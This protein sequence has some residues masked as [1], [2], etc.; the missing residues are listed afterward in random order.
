M[1]DL[2]P[3]TYRGRLAAV[4]GARRFYLADEFERRSP[5]DPERGMVLFM[6][7]YA[8]D[9]AAGVAPG[10]YCDEDARR[11]ARNCLLAPGLGELLERSDL[12]VAYISTT[13]PRSIRPNDPQ[14]T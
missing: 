9:V 1:I 11:Y 13:S 10:P 5:G 6:C 8:L 14:S 3:I 2:Q 12:D 7:A 4:A